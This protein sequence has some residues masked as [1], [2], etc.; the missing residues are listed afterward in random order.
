MATVV[1]IAI[2][3]TIQWNGL[4]GVNDVS[5]IAQAV[6]LIVSAGMAVHVF[7]VWIHPYHNFDILEDITPDLP[8]LRGGTTTSGSGSTG[9]EESNTTSS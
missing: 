4:W 6:P 3:L 1:V 7:Y 5:T 9:D 8:E 2:E